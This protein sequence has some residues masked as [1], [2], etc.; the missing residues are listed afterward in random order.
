MDKALAEI[1]ESRFLVVDLT[2]NRPS[3]FFEAG[4][5]HGLGIEII[6]V[7]KEGEGTDLEFYAKHYQCYKYSSPDELRELVKN[8]ISARI[9]K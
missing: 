6:F 1:R 7:Y 8:A 5:A 2:K 4:F 9:K 3:V